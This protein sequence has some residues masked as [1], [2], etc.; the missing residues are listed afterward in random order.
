MSIEFE[1]HVLNSDG[2]TSELY[3]IY[4]LSLLLSIL[5]LGIYHFWGKTRKRRYITSSLSLD[6]DR[7]EYTGYGGE[8]LLGLIVGII[9]LGVV[10]L[11]FIWATYEIEEANQYYKEHRTELPKEQKGK[12]VL[13]HFEQQD[14][15]KKNKLVGEFS[16][17][18]DF[19]IQYNYQGFF[20]KYQ[21][22]LLDIK[23]NISNSLATFD[24]DVQFAPLEN[25]LLLTAIILTPLYLIFYFIY[26]P[27]VIVYGSLRYRATR[28]RWRGIRGDL[29]GSS[30]LYGLIGLVYFFL[31]IVTLGL[32]IPISD[33]R[34]LKYKIQK[35]YFGNQQANF[36]PNM[37]TIFIAHL[38]SMGACLYMI[39]L[40]IALG[41]WLLPFIVSFA[42]KEEHLIAQFINSLLKE[43]YFIS[44]IFLI[45]ICYVPRYWYRAALLR[46]K[47]NS[48]QFGDIQF[49]C[50]ASG[51]EY[52]K[53]FIG[54]DFIFIFTLSF[55]LPIIWQRRMK[56]FCKHIK[57][58][59]DIDKLC[60][61][62]ALGKKT[63]FGG[64]FASVMNLEIGLI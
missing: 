59:G 32:W 49:R 55:G 26:L 51:Y 28:L 7:F 47:Y 60:I 24:L 16:S 56:F 54:N 48:L 37:Q 45:W 43:G 33:V 57:V 58:I 6:K 36:T 15:F 61:A 42:S 23:W 38:A 50:N 40:M 35:L 62:Q 46:E 63:K 10:S 12:P 34:M 5:T 1:K 8:L 25:L 27:F 29:A 13:Y 44:I 2:K 18:T 17:F 9:L 53:L 11:P 19:W 21:G 39:V 3:K 22:D 4:L 41:Y 64:G 20:I 30:L 14:P 31:K 52:F